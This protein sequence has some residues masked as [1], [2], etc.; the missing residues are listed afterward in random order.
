M[1]KDHLNL[2]LEIVSLLVFLGSLVAVTVLAGLAFNIV[3]L[4]LTDDLPPANELEA[5]VRSRGGYLIST[6]VI[7]LFVAFPL[8]AAL[9][10]RL[11]LVRPEPSPWIDP[12]EPVAAFRRPTEDCS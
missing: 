5:I 2:L 4:E 3:G 9:L 6:L 12:E 10:I 1:R 7:A 8:A 11:F